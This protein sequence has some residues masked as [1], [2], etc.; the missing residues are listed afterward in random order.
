M[1]QATCTAGAESDAAAAAEAAEP[2]LVSEQELV[3]RPRGGAA[4]AARPLATM[5]QEQSGGLVAANGR[6]HQPSPAAR[7]DDVTARLPSVR[8]LL[9]LGHAPASVTPSV[10]PSA[11]LSVTATA[12][13]SGS[14]SSSPSVSPTRAASQSLSAAVSS[15]SSPHAHRLAVGVGHRHRIGQ[16][17]RVRVAVRRGHALRLTD[18]QPFS[19]VAVAVPGLLRR[20]RGRGAGHR[21]QLRLRQL[22]PQSATGGVHARDGTTIA[23]RALS[24]DSGARGLVA[25]NGA[26]T[27]LC[28]SSS[29]LQGCN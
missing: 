24:A 1:A 23:R 3:C 15:S 27:N 11:T 6:V 20:V 8:H 29:C 18:G 2:L 13:A 12:S 28:S 7:R 5:V 16:R 10:T 19:R 17:E 26:C 21:R 22:L 4:E 25:V 14:S 9:R